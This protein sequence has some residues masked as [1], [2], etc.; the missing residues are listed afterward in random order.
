LTSLYSIAWRFLTCALLLLSLS[1][2]VVARSLPQLDGPRLNL[3]AVKNFTLDNTTSYNSWL[4][5]QQSKLGDIL[6]AKEF[7]RRYPAVEAASLHPGVIATNLGRHLTFMDYV[8]FFTVSVPRS[9][10][11]EGRINFFKSPQ[12]GASTT[13]V[14]ATTP[15]LVNGAYY[16]NCQVDDPTESAK[17]DDDAKALFDYCDEVTK[18]YQ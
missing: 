10:A 3:D 4:A 11:A 14:V 17:N 8:R 5:Y 12:Q 7:H 6:L 1:R 18:A 2:L 9:I 15:D 13:L 16:R